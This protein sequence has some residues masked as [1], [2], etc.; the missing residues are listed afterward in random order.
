[1][2]TRPPAVGLLETVLRFLVSSFP[3][4]SISLRDRVIS[5]LG[6]RESG[7]APPHVVI[8]GGPSAYLCLSLQ[9][10]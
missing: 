1:M 5:S 4:Q 7:T 2:Q 6:Q 9:S 8:H 10:S 3:P